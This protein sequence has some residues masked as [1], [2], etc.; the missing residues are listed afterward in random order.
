[1]RL[2]DAE[3]FKTVIFNADIFWQIHYLLSLEL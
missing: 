2:G 3:V 1:M